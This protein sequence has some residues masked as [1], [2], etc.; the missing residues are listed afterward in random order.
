M[1]ELIR[2]LHLSKIINKLKK[3]RPIGLTNLIKN[4]VNNTMRIYFQLQPLQP[5][6]PAGDSTP[7]DIP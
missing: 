4:G 6:N 3:D 7:P 1:A 2:T 5:C